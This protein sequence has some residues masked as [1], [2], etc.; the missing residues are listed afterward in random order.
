MSPAR[1]KFDPDAPRK[2]D[3]RR[4]LLLESAEELLSE[5]PADKLT[6]DDVAAR[7]GLSRSGVYFYFDSKW[8][9]LDALIDQRS[10]ELT[11]RALDGADD[12]SIPDLCQQF[13]DAALFSWR[14]HGAIFNAAVERASHGGDATAA[15]RAVMCQCVDALVPRLADNS[16]VDTAAIGDAR[17][18]V[19]MA[20]WMVERNFYMLFS[21]QHTVKEERELAAAL[22]E[23]ALRI[24]GVH[25]AQG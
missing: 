7:A 11:Q 19:E 15:W 5:I 20:S 24:L 9:L 25:R 13:V 8:A 3:Q 12:M 23:A 18:T 6:L 10:T 17:T 16:A 4:E 22:V 1:R 2:G 21:R 14:N